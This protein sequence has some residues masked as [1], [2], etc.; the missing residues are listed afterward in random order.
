MIT[1]SRAATTGAPK[2][3]R[4]QHSGAFRKNV[5]KFVAIWYANTFCFL[6]L[7][8]RGCTFVV[9]RVESVK[10]ILDF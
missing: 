5:A 10:N 8:S 2:T 7:E 6:F 9:S 4:A 3:T 1:D